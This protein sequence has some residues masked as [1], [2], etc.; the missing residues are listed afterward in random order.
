MVKLQ[1]QVVDILIKV[2]KENKVPYSEV[3]TI[4]TSLFNFLISEFSE[5]TDE[6]EETWS[7]NI[8]V[9]NFGKFVVNKNKVR[10]YEEFK[11]RTSKEPNE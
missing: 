5:I 8:I 9:K 7:K 10:K 4:Y 2:A 3:K 1:D 11:R 6:N